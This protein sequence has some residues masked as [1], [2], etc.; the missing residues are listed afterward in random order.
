MLD[1]FKKMS[2]DA[3]ADKIA[4]IIRAELDRWESKQAGDEASSAPSQVSGSPEDK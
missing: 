1:S 4:A 3:D 2:P